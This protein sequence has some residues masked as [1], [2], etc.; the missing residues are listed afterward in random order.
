MHVLLRLAPHLQ[1]RIGVRHAN[2][3]CSGI[4]KR[5]LYL[6]NRIVSSRFR[7][8]ELQGINDLDFWVR[9]I[10]G[11]ALD[12]MVVE[13]GWILGVEVKASVRSSEDFTDVLF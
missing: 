3:H 4:V 11:R 1:A 12:L 13:R 2:R 7:I 9:D 10:R 8:L 6:G 5:S